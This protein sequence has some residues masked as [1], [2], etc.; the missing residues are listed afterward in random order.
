MREEDKKKYQKLSGF[1]G[2][3]PEGDIKPSNPPKGDSRP[4]PTPNPP[5]PG[6]ATHLVDVNNVT[7]VRVL[8]GLQRYN[9]NVSNVTHSKYE[10][11]DGNGDYVRWDQIKPIIDMLKG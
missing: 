9:I 5:R 7:L 6:S 4:T 8:N 2:Y 10:T 3:Q 1:G 11:K